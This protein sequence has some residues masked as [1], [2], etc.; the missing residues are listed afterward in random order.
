MKRVVSR[1]LVVK[2]ES[3]A[4]E[5]TAPSRADSAFTLVEMLLVVVL[6]ATLTGTL[7]VSLSGRV[8][9]HA[10]RIAGKDLAAAV[11]FSV[12]ETRLKRLPHRV[13]FHDNWTRYRVERAES[14]AGGEYVPV[15]SLAGQ[16]KTLAKQVRIAGASTDGQPLES[17]PEAL[18]QYPDGNGFHGE[19][20]LANRAGE[21]LT[22][23]VAP[24]TGQVQIVE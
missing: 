6:L 5:C 14:A 8:D 4:P 17:L 2:T 21:T 3:L 15:R 16:I 11:R 9:R 12:A 10:L 18:P 1:E 20:Q 13:A 19:I 7:A 24:V 22:I 23:K